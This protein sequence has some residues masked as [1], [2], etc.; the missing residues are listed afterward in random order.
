MIHAAYSIDKQPFVVSNMNR[1][2]LMKHLD[3]LI[4]LFGSRMSLGKITET[5]DEIILNKERI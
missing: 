1:E 3:E 4:I 5:L 2:M